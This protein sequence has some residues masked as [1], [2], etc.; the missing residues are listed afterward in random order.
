MFF[1]QFEKTI[2]FT[3]HTNQKIKKN[4]NQN[5]TKIQIKIKNRKLK[6]ENRKTDY[7][8]DKYLSII[9]CK[10]WCINKQHSITIH[11][12][13]R[14]PPF[15]KTKK[16]LKVFRKKKKASKKILKSTKYFYVESECCVWLLLRT[17]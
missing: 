9:P 8:I 13:T 10:F 7:N 6:I 14:C 4:Q 17:M 12:T 11:N 16:K 5:R 2:H 1:H 15:G 3:T